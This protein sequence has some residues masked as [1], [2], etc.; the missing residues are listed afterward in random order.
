MPRQYT[1]I[2]LVIV[3]LLAGCSRA[4][5]DEQTP[6]PIGEKP[7]IDVHVNHTE[8]INKIAL[9][10][11]TIARGE[12]LF[13]TAFNSLDGLGRPNADARGRPRTPS[14][15]RL[16]FDRVKG[17]DSS[18]CAGCHNIPIT[19]G[20]GD[21]ASNVFILPRLLP[22]S[23]KSDD[24]N[25]RLF[26]QPHLILPGNERNTPGMFGTGY[27]E[28]LA[29]E[30]TE[31][32]WLMRDKGVQKAQ[33]Q[34]QAVTVDLSTKGIS[35]GQITI[36]LD[37]VID[38][39]NLDGIDKDLIIKPFQSTGS[40]VSLREFTVIA[41]NFHHGMQ[42]VELVGDMIDGD[43]DSIINELTRGDITAMVLFQATLPVPQAALTTNLIIQE[44]EH[45]FNNIGCASCH[46]PKLPLNSPI[47]TEPSPF[48]PPEIMRPSDVS[49]LV[50][51]DLTDHMQGTPLEKDSSGTIWVSAYTDLKRHDMG[52]A[53]DNEKLL[54]LSQNG[55]DNEILIGTSRTN[56]VLDGFATERV[57][58][59]RSS[60][61]LTKRL[62]TAGDDEPY[63][64][65]GLATLLT[66]A[67]MLHGGEAQASKEAFTKLDSY[68]QSTI[69]DFLKSLR[70]EQG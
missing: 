63:M 19:G 44:G 40:V 16:L 38:Y 28:L 1:L 66:E 12:Q 54:L 68:K 2:G 21:N 13:S 15:D 35:F 57:R 14:E 18:S 33:E 7:A 50:S 5:H 48:N 27:I 51:I 4:Q 69:I 34:A 62:W 65:H 9:V 53:L 17:P 6:A 8:V 55:A 10:S 24:A 26:N 41:S 60:E 49:A 43:G 46:I 31:D 30:M 47:F 67:I 23:S 32:L 20:A 3:V 37:G 61:W 59:R 52:P 70:I 42:A 29:R 64:H 56:G 36:T 11:D 39:T 45:L 25:A 22:I 58:T